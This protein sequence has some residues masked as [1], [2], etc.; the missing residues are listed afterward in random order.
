MKDHPLRNKL[1]MFWVCHDDIPINTCQICRIINGAKGKHDIKFCRGN[2]KDEWKGKGNFKSHGN[3]PYPN[4]KNCEW[5]LAQV[6]Y[7]LRVLE[8]H[9]DFGVIE[10]RIEFRADPIVPNRKDRMR[11]WAPVGCLPKL[12]NHPEFIRKRES[13]TVV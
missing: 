10:S 11:M 9:K 13:K 7:H 2:Q 12:T 5:K 8:N 6:W 3:F 4:C 1:I